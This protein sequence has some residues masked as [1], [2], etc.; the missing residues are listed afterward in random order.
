MDENNNNSKT[1]TQANIHVQP[2]NTA[3]INR[4][5]TDKISKKS[6][7]NLNCTQNIC[8]YTTIIIN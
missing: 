4:N 8:T 3:K 5:Y 7:K 1:V 6:S 2:K